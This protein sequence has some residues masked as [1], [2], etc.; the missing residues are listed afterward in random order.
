LLL[1]PLGRMPYH[2]AYLTY[3]AFS[4]AAVLAFLVLYIRIYPELITFAALSVPLLINFLNGQ[5][6]GLATAFA[7]FAMILH[8]RNKSFWAGAVLMLATIKFHLFVLVAVAIV[9]HRKWNIL[10]GT[11]AGGA[12]LLLLSIAADGFG[13]PARFLAMVRNPELHPGPDHMTTFRNLAWTISGGENKALEMAM[14][15]VVAGLFVYLAWRI[16]DFNAVIGLALVGGLVICHHAYSQDLMLLLLAVPLI[17]TSTASKAVRGITM[18]A[19]L[20]PTAFV[21]YSG[22]PYS[23]LV[24]LL[25]TSIL[26][27]ALIFDAHQS[28][29]SARRGN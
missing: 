19:A 16:K 21:L 1:S 3:Q 18:V 29:G 7:G 23:A 14:N 4:L 26:L 17:V 13:W 24:P 25:L 11:I 27:A 10:K 15:L 20:P 8:S 22:F 6:S 28:T 9:V 12:V 2:A 5:D